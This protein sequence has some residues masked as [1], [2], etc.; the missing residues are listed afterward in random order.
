[1]HLPAITSIL[2][3]F[4]A[5]LALPSAAQPAPPRSADIH[6][7]APGVWLLPGRFERGR[8][9]DGNSLLLQGP[10]GIVIVDSGRHAEHTQALLD[11]VRASGR[12]LRA[13]LNT[14]WHLDHLGGNAMLRDAVPALRAHATPAVRDAVRRRMPASATDL[15]RMKADPQLDEATRRMVEID[16]A[17]YTRRA[18]LEPDMLIEGP[19]QDLTLA[20]R[21][22]RVGVAFGVSGGDLWLLDP[23][24]GTLVVGDFVTLPVPFFDTACPERWQRSLTQLAALP[25]ERVV[26]GHG[27]VMNRADFD[28]YRVAYDRLL[29]CAAGPR[30]VA[31]CSAGWVAD[32]GPLLPASG[33]RGA[34]GM[35][36]H[37]LEQRLRAEPARTAADCAAG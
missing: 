21:P 1:M 15:E 34:H 14:H 2:A 25:F 23:A 9:P 18:A 26:P 8:Q 4:A 33:E 31:D 5:A 28:R 27:P 13:V 36:K 32:L 37:Y 10:D 20:G 30:A 19:A 35:L 29:A 22:L 3:A 7:L 6:A 24:S 16:L 12:P 17:L 11:W